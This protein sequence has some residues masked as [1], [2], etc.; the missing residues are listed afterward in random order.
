MFF[1]NRKKLEIRQR[2]DAIAGSRKRE[3]KRRD[4]FSS[5]ATLSAPMFPQAWKRR[6]SGMGCFWCRADCFGRLDGV[7]STMVGYAGGAHARMPPIRRYALARPGINEVVR[8]R[9]MILAVITFDDLLKS[10]GIRPRFLPRD[11]SG[12]RYGTPVSQRHLTYYAGAEKKPPP[13]SQSHVRPAFGKAGFGDI[14]TELIDRADI[15]FA[16]I[17]HQ[18]N[19][20]PRNPRAIL[21]IGGGRA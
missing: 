20:S 7:Y 15:Y 1:M 5:T 21:R 6:C 18:A 14:T 3:S 19:T 10:S 13:T 17:T 8:V 4:A 16:R 9:L 12:Q 11:A 2:E